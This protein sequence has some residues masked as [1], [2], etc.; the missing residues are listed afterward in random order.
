MFISNLTTTQQSIF[1]TLANNLIQS[2]GILAP[3]EAVLIAS[4]KSQ[5]PS[6]I[7]AADYTLDSLANFFPGK[8]E[9]ASTLLE[10]IGLGHADD[11]FDASEKD[12]IKQI[13]T[14]F[15]ITSDEL[16]EMQSWVVRQLSI[17]RQANEF[18]ED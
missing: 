7:T 1:L 4:I 2:D 9:K 5:M 17:V 6:N 13:C 10:L 16:N 8:K 12:F 15:K 14:S 18:M 11:D 3:Q